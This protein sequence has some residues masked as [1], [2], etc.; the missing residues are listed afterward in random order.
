[1]IKRNKF[2]M[3]GHKGEI[4]AL[5]DGVITFRR[6]NYKLYNFELPADFKL[7]DYL[8]LFMDLNYVHGD[9]NCCRFRFEYVDT[10]IMDDEV[11]S[12]KKLVEPFG[13]FGTWFAH[14]NNDGTILFSFFLHDIKVAI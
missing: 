6:K 3:Q 12:L 10:S 13:S 4:I 8:N 1:M 7:R 2:R 5:N 11:D 14:F 9:G